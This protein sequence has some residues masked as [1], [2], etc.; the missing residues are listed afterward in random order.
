[1][2][3]LLF[4]LGIIWLLFWSLRPKGIMGEA[5]VS[6]KVESL[7]GENSEYQSFDGLIL[8]TADGTTQIDHLIVSP[9][10]IF[11]IE[12]KNLKGWIFGDANQKKWTQSLPR[13]YNLYSLFNKYTF[14]FQNPLHQNYKHVKA[15]QK[16][17][18]VDEKFIFS[19][20]VFTGDS[21]FKTDM[22]DNVVE[23]RNFPAHLKSYTERVLSSGSVAKFAQKL[24]DYVEHAPINEAEHVR[25]IK[26]N[27]IQPICPRC[28]KSMILRVA[29]KGSRV[30]L[31][32]WGC[33][34]FPSC[35]VIKR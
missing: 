3:E 28:G 20:V 12:T 5:M 33:P 13:R 7:I 34:N 9:Y 2:L 11:V 14:Q 32:F 35:K 21:E 26:Q 1:M 23:L 17:F 18:G 22:P 4:I 25:N 19:I 31:Q 15:V 29:S 8:K 16:F 24:S 6:R 10:G 30:G 27:S